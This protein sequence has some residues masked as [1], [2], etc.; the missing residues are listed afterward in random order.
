MSQ[1]SEIWQPLRGV[2]FPKMTITIVGGGF[3]GVLVATQLLKHA[4]TPLEIKLIESKS[5]LGRGVA[6]GTDISCH[7]LNVPAGKMSAFPDEPDHFFNWLEKQEELLKEL[8][9]E[10][11]TTGTFVPRKIYGIYGQAILE[12]AIRNAAPHVTFEWIKEDAIDISPLGENKEITL[13]NG[14]KII[15]QK[16]VLALGNFP[17]ANPSIED[18][19]FYQ[20]H[21]HY[22]SY[23]WGS[24]VFDLIKPDENI[25]LIGSGLTMVDIAIGLKY[26]N[27]QGRIYVVSRHG[28]LPQSH[29]ETQPYQGLNLTKITPLSI[30][31]LLR[32]V[33]QIIKQAETQGIN[34]RGVIDA[35]RPETQV[36]WQSLSLE[37]K[38]RFLRHLRPYWEI[39]RH[40][41]A[42][43]I[44][45][46]LQEILNSHQLQVMAGKVQKF[47]VTPKGVDVFVKPRHSNNKELTRLTVNRVINCTGSECDY[48]QF[49]HPLIVNLR[50]RG[51]MSPDPL[52]LGL[53]VASNGALIGEK[54]VVSS[55][56]Y[57]L[58]SPRKG[59]LWETTAIP[60]IR[61]HAIAL[62]LEVG[63]VE[64]IN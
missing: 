49:Q 51:L 35:I 6:Y 38:R 27:H 39:H 41:V 61:Q 26:Q 45:G 50:D 40:R 36:L 23:P 48:R 11:L 10:T 28:F 33:R 22:I 5:V 17:P 9:D 7:V 62:S 37:E 8:G 4:M 44:F 14:E 43:K 63:W 16:I 18:P 46:L 55:W 31:N 64:K 56:L 59:C 47:A 1:L 12:D 25:L 53:D 58:G 13:S 34:W 54:G 24:H 20:D 19:S 60:E 3:S 29:Q 30:R 52:N 15:A 2:L 32:Q 42:P 57:T 21:E